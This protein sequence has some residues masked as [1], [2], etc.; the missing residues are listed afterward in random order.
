MQSP[1]PSCPSATPPAGDYLGYYSNNGSGEEGGRGREGTR[2]E[3]G[4]L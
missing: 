1:P 4:W 2:E 3:E